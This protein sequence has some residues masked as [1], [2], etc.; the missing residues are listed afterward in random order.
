MT[1]EEF[2]SRFFKR[3]SHFWSLSCWLTPFIFYSRGVFTSALFIYCLRPKDLGCVIPKTLKMVLDTSLLNTLQYKVLSRVKWSNPRKGV[4]PSSTPRCSSYL[5]GSILVA[6]DY[7]R[8]FYLL[9]MLIVI[10]YLLP[11][12]WFYR[13]GLEC[14]VVILFS[15]CYFPM[16]VL[17]F[18][19]FVGFLLFR[20]DVVFIL[21]RLSVIVI[22]WLITLHLD[23]GLVGM[24]SAAASISVVTTFLYSSFGVCLW[25]VPWRISNFSRHLPFNVSLY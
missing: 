8:Q 16:V 20:K 7:G 22:A 15:K 2:L 3:F 11:S 17:S 21:S 10:V 18:W 23:L 25:D 19:V 4:A 5:K 12:F 14:I 24:L 9:L 1:V 13:F 6:L